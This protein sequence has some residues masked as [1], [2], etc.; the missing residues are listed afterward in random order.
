MSVFRNG[1]AILLS[2]CCFIIATNAQAQ[3]RTAERI[4]VLESR[5]YQLESVIVQMNQR[6]NALEYGQRP[7]P[8]PQTPI[9][10]EIAC[11]IID[12]GHSK[13]YLGKGRTQIEAEANAREA[14]G[15]S[16]H[17]SY[18][19]TTAKCDER[20]Q[21]VDGATCMLVD[22]GHS[23]TFKGDGKSLVEAEYKARKSCSD[24][25]HA[26]YC[27]TNVRCDTY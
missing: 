25:V 8:Y 21:L 17:S 6:I 27:K 1:F 5:V 15:K 22:S 11:M 3:D 4:R 10:S 2:V 18:C 24:S 7:F 20:N 12:S 26:V 9:Q 19:T 13:S 14:C 23:K 16:T